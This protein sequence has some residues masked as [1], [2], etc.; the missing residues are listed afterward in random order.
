MSNVLAIAAVTEAIRQ[1]LERAIHSPDL[2]DPSPSAKESI[3]VTVK[4]PDEFKDMTAPALNLFLYQ[5]TTNP[6]L[7]NMVMPGSESDVAFPPLALKLHY[8]LTAYGGDAELT[9]QRLLGRAITTLHRNPIFSPEDLAGGIAESDLAEQLDRVRVT[10]MALSTEELSRFW[11]TFGAPYRVS[12]AYEAS[13]VLIDPARSERAPL[14]VLTRGPVSGRVG[15]WSSSRVEAKLVPA[16]PG[17]AEVVIEEEETI[18]AVTIRKRVPRARPGAYIRVLGHALGAGAGVDVSL[19][20]DSARLDAPHALTPTK[21]TPTELEARLPLAPGNQWL[22]GLYSIAVVFSEP[23]LPDRSTAA[24]PFALAPTIALHHTSVLSG[25]DVYEVNLTVDVSP[26][27]RQGQRISL[28]IGDRELPSLDSGSSLA[29]VVPNVAKGT[30]YVR[31]RV[32]GIDSLLVL[33]YGASLPQ[34]DP[35]QA[36][37]VP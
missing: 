27:I 14:P 11:S 37:Q 25:P 8:L 22:A 32:D 4:Q 35:T 19:I 34:F 13:V 24:L 5:V 15:P 2:Q 1:R 21:H 3:F 36:L 20:V 9:S 26:E 33:D 29:F 30:H 28:L 17:I 31:L 6:H 12:M 18:G 7:A 23:G 10:P 16:A